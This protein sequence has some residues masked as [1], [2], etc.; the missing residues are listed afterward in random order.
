MLVLKALAIAQIVLKA[1]A[2]LGLSPGCFR[3]P[4][5]A[6]VSADIYFILTSKMPNADE[7]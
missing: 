5:F 6:A 1:L 4:P 7:K 3:E 2:L